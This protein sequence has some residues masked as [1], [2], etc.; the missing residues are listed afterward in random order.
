MNAIY[1]VD[2]HLKGLVNR[3]AQAYDVMVTL[4]YFL[5]QRMVFKGTIDFF[6]I[7]RPEIYT[8]ECLVVIDEYEY[9]R[10]ILFDID[11]K[12]YAWY[13]MDD[14]SKHPTYNT[15]EAYDRAMKGI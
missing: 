11:E 10:G 8:I 5:T 9:Q 12:A 4:E 3:K 14:R 7:T 13:V 6:N 15:N 1:E 2:N